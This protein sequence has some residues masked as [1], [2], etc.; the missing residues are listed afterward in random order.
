MILIDV[1]QIAIGVLVNALSETNEPDLNMIRHSIINR[2]WDIQNKYSE[3]YGNVVLCYD[4]NTYWRKD[5]F[6]NYKAGRK[7]D[8]ANSTLDWNK[9]FDISNLLR[10]EFN[11]YLPYKVMC[12]QNAEADDIIAVLCR[13]DRDNKSSTLV[14]SGDKDFKQLQK[15]SSIHIYNPQTQILSVSTTE[16]AELY[17]KEHIIRG[18]RSDGIPNILSGDNCFVDGIRQKPITKKNIGVWIDQNKQDIC[19]NSVDMMY[20]YNRNQVLVDFDYIPQDLSTIILDEYKNQKNK[21][22][23]QDMFKYFYD[24]G[25]TSLSSKFSLTTI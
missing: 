5:Y 25:L 2:F 3:I 20:N 1:N 22:T 21:S 13:Y 23:K 16:D 9:L 24:F 19:A 10:E 12:I 18:D 15:Y 11:K 7:K 6:P 14:V 17:L 8:R 4:S